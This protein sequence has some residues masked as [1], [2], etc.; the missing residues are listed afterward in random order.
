MTFLIKI[1]H[2]R[3]NSKTLY[4]AQYSMLTSLLIYFYHNPIT[5]IAFLR[6]DTVTRVHT[7][8][9]R[10]KTIFIFIVDSN[11]FPRKSKMDASLNMTLRNKLVL[12][13]KYL[14]KMD[15][16]RFLEISSYLFN[17]INHSIVHLGPQ[18]AIY[19]SVLCTI[20][21]NYDIFVKAIGNKQKLRFI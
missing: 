10:Q 4:V 1:V 3:K 12:N 2:N 14:Q 11:L 21:S 6:Y 18:L 13:E 16:K 9:W 20:V 17:L 5:S 8:V 19:H 15:C 7:A